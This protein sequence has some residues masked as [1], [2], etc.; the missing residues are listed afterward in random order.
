M[1]HD[2]K[3]RGSYYPHCSSTQRIYSKYGDVNGIFVIE[4]ECLCF[5]AKVLMVS[6]KSRDIII[7]LNDIVQVETMNLNG[8]MPF[9]VCVFTRDGKEYMFGHMQNKKLARFI[10]NEAHII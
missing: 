9:G 5:H 7:P 3:M 10:K 8:F 4:N 6:V 1:S 2:K